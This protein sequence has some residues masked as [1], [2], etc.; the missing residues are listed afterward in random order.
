MNY[1][2]PCPSVKF[3][4]LILDWFLILMSQCLEFKPFKIVHIREIEKSVLLRKR[5]HP[6]FTNSKR[7]KSEK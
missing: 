2:L 7:C 4:W 1:R 3:F 6:N 5:T